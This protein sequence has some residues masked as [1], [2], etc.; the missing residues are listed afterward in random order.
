MQAS[1][2][3][4]EKPL[5][6][7]ILRQSEAIKARFASRHETKSDP[8]DPNAPPALP[9]AQATTTAEPKPGDAPAPAADPRHADPLYWKQ[10]FQ[11]VE[12]RLKVREDEHKAEVH[13]LHQQLTELA[14]Q[15]RSLHANA[16]QPQTDV[17][18]FLTPEQVELLGADEAQTIV[19]AVLI[20]ARKEV[21]KLVDAEIK[22][23]REA[24]ATTQAT[25]HEDLKRQFLAKLEELVP[26]FAEVDAT[27]EWK[28]WLQAEDEV[29]GV[30]RQDAM[31]KHISLANAGGVAKLFKAFKA[32]LPK[33]PA[34]PVAPNGSGAGSSGIPQASASAGLTVPT[35]AEIKDFYKR[36]STVRKGQPGYV[37]DQEALTFEKRL[38]LK[39][40]GR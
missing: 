10:R 16:P 36:K 18:E 17:S 38:K 14:E 25:T 29:T 34:P 11:V 27:D 24:Q 33:P 22:P 26:D 35:A 6:R 30:P 9:S 20:G 40:T 7:A 21:A 23:L 19:D 3:P 4:N 15:I 5:P 1:T 12:G 13:G 39:A 31:N 37:T 32:S 8:V 2:A 28:L